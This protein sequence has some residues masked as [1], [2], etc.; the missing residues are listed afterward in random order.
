MEPKS[1]MLL[2]VNPSITI[3]MVNALSLDLTVLSRGRFKCIS[4]LLQ[5]IMICNKVTYAEGQKF[6]SG[7]RVPPYAILALNRLLP[8]PVRR[9]QGPVFILHDES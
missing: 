7:R 3:L 8:T 6:T 1:S 5:L 9:D 4:D 2:S